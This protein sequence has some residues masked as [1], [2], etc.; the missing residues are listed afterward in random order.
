[1]IHALTL[2]CILVFAT[3]LVAIFHWLS[4]REFLMVVAYNMGE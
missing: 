1:M 2:L 4:S 3:P